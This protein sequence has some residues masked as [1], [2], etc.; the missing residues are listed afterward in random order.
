MTQHFKSY[1]MLPSTAGGFSPTC[2]RL[3][4][5]KACCTRLKQ[6]Y[7]VPHAQAG[8]AVLQA[9]LQ[10]ALAVMLVMTQ[11]SDVQSRRAAV[12]FIILRAHHFASE[13]L[14]HYPKRCLSLW[15]PE[16]WPLVQ[17]TGVAQV[18]N[19]GGLKWMEQCHKAI[20]GF[21]FPSFNAVPNGA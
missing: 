15:V 7:Q 12:F 20:G 2:A 13:A 8:G 10:K 21:W 1:R 19:S 11:P 4:T 6:S 17:K 16:A 3:C 9:H 5:N 14:G 18:A